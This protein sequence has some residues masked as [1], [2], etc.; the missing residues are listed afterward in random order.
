[1]RRLKVLSKRLTFKG[2]D[3]ILRLGHI[4][5]LAFISAVTEKNR[6]KPK[7]RKKKTEELESEIARKWDYLT[8]F[9]GW[10]EYPKDPKTKKEDKTKPGRDTIE[11]S[12]IVLGEP[13]ISD[14]ESKQKFIKDMC[15]LCKK[16]GQWAVMIL[17]GVEQIDEVTFKQLKDRY[18]AYSVFGNPEYIKKKMRKQMKDIYG[19]EIERSFNC[20]EQRVLPMAIYRV[21]ANYYS[22]ENV[23]LKHYENVSTSRI[24]DYFTTVFRDV[25]APKF[26][27]IADDIEYH[28][29]FQPTNIRE[30]RIVPRGAD[31]LRKS[32]IDN[33]DTFQY[34]WINCVR[35]T[36]LNLA[37]KII[38]LFIK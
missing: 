6:N 9:G 4:M 3:T 25:N 13:Y 23:V 28:S 22:P 19:D 14:E 7:L 10:V 36:K 16:Y 38:K 37:D 26:T 33:R 27:F 8:S 2:M 5:Q 12:F 34:K 21:D 30:A 11:E 35:Y 17:E 15:E 24:A 20:I 29:R 31:V 32:I 18:D 1:M